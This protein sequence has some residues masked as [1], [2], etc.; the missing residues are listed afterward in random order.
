M[1]AARR[2]RCEEV[3]PLLVFLACNEVTADERAGMES[4]LLGCAECRLQLTEV[5]RFHESLTAVPQAADELDRTGTLLAQ[6]RSELS[7]SLDEMSAPPVEQQ[8]WRPFGFAR[9]WMALRPGWSAAGLLAAGAILGVQLLKWLPAGDSGFMGTQVSVSAAPKLTDDQLAKMA[10]SQINVAPNAEGE[11]GMF[12]VQL[13]AE[14]PVVLSGNLDNSDMRRVLT[15]VVK[16]SDRFDPGVRLDCLDALRAKIGDAEIRDALLEAARRDNNPAVRMKA[17]ESLREVASEEDVRDAVL[18]ALEQD[19]NPGVR[20][21]AINL[22]VRSLEVEP[23][24]PPAPDMNSDVP[25]A[26][27]TLAQSDP[28]VQRVLHAL[29]Q[30]RRSDPNHYVRLRSA[31]ALRQIGPAEVQ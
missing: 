19:A 6:C 31:A 10:V 16:N 27:A 3:A 26:P 22:L 11:P 7:E 30:L 9:R 18:E 5:G 4:H 21:E 28:S 13:R 2:M 24:M 29:E 20:V 14:Q 25:M 12:Q 17:L 1:S 15:Y 23:A 8:S